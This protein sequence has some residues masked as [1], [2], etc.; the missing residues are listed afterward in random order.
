MRFG[1]RVAA[2]SIVEYRPINSSL[3]IDG[4][5]VQTPADALTARVRS[6]IA[7]SSFMMCL[8]DMLFWL[9]HFAQQSLQVIQLSLNDLHVPDA[10]E[11]RRDLGR[12]VARRFQELTS[13]M[14]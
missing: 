3:D 9:F 4:L 6:M 10:P 14:D 13:C 5:K 2:D 11:A 7:A 1:Y 12:Q 8:S